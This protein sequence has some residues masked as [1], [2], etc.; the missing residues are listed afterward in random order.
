VDVLLDSG[1]ECNVISS[2][3]FDALKNA[4]GCEVRDAHTIKIK[5]ACNQETKSDQEIIITVKHQDKE[6]TMP[7]RHYPALQRDA[8]IGVDGL[9]ILG[10]TLKFSPSEKTAKELNDELP[11][12]EICQLTSEELLTVKD[13]LAVTDFTEP[14]PAK[15]DVPSRAPQFKLSNPILETLERSI[16]F[17]NILKQ[18]SMEENV[19][20]CLDAI[21]ALGP[22][23]FSEGY[24]VS[25]DKLTELDKKDTDN[26]KYRFTIQWMINDKTN[27]DDMPRVWNSAKAIEKLTDKHAAEWNEHVHGYLNQAWWTP[28]EQQK[29]KIDLSAVVFP[30]VQSAEKTTTLRPCSDFRRLNRASPKI[31]AVTPSVATAVLE[32]RTFYEADMIIKQYDLAKAFYKIGIRVKDNDR[33]FEPIL[34]VGNK[35]YTSDRL[36]FGLSCGPSGL[37]VTQDIINYVI[38]KALEHNHETCLKIKRIVVMDDYLVIG[39]QDAVN[40]LQTLL[41]YTWTTTGFDSPTKK[42]T[43]WNSN[44]TRWL[45]AHWT[46]EEHT[47][48]VIRPKVDL[49]ITGTITK[50]NVFAQAGKIMNFCGSPNETIART[51]ADILRILSGKITEWDKPI[52]DL[53]AVKKIHEHLS[54]ANKHYQISSREETEVST[55]AHVHHMIL[56]CDASH[57]GFGYVIMVKDNCVQASARIFSD[58][59]RVWHINRKELYA[60]ALSMQQLDTVVAL[61]PRLRSIQIRTDSKVALLQLNEFVNYNSKSIEKRVLMRLRQNIFDTWNYWRKIGVDVSII[62]IKGVDNKA[63]KLTRLYQPATEDPLELLMIEEVDENVPIQD[64][65]ENIYQAQQNDPKIQAAKT[66]KMFYT[67]DER[68]LVRHTNGQVYV[69]ETLAKMIMEKLHHHSGHTKLHD[70]LVQF[71]F[72]ILIGRKLQMVRFY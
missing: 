43:A 19:N 31:S 50:R 20:A 40:E 8:I 17:E 63:D 61:L 54:L 67:T 4:Q 68:G 27:P 37:N 26:Q 25:L 22:I 45:G 24:K 70:L 66:N 57:T 35:H 7:F 64:W 41:D 15:E 71:L 33:K 29:S 72:K 34:K 12:T 56:E 21:S 49:E 1:A 52:Q 47:I 9:H 51:H 46:L 58:K 42:R 28:I 14:P 23:P 39:P 59:Q 60:L 48:R 69:S 3:L 32:L 38:D 10:A 13:E 65:N 5:S 62:H 36:V 16:D 44:P 11:A 2:R 30:V 18:Q 53:A 55:L 6:W